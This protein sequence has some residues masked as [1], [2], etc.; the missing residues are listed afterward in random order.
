MNEKLTGEEKIINYKILN[1]S[2][3]EDKVIVEVF[4]TVY[5]DITD[6]SKIEEQPKNEK[7]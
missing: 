7:N 2:V 3:E 4:F 6:Y 5:E 1:S